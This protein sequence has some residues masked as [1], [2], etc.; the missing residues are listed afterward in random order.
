MTVKLFPQKGGDLTKGLENQEKSQKKKS[1][2]KRILVN[3]T[4]AAASAISSLSSQNAKNTK[5][6]HKLYS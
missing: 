1:V 4:P 6:T 2:K 3:K 5:I